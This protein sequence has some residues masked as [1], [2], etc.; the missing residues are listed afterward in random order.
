VARQAENFEVSGGFVRPAPKAGWV[1]TGE[2]T[3]VPTLIEAQLFVATP[4][5]RVF[6]LIRIDGAGKPLVREFAITTNDVNASV[7]TTLLRQLPVDALVREALSRAT[8]RIQ[9]RP[10]MH[11]RAFHVPG[12]ADHEAWVSPEPAPTGRGKKVPQ[13]RVARAAQVYLQALAAGSNAPAEVVAST[14]HYSRATAARDIR[15]A[16]SRKPPLLPALGAEAEWL[17]EHSGENVINESSS[18]FRLS[19]EPEG[20]ERAVAEALRLGLESGEP[21]GRTVPHP[22]VD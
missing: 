9:P 15:A 12:D 19:T 17:A 6:M 4:A 18:T 16:R 11:E 14:L 8:V 21:E 2:L 13:D 1:R 10:D 7:S 22:G 3:A 5:V 20:I